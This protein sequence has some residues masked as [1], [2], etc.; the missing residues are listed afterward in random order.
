MPRPSLFL[1]LHGESEAMSRYYQL[2]LKRIKAIYDEIQDVRQ[3][4][5]NL[6]WVGRIPMVPADDAEIMAR[7]TGRI[8]IA[9]LIADDQIGVVRA[10]Q[11]IRLQEVK[12]PNLK[13]GMKISQEMLSL[14]RRIEG[15]IATKGDATIF[16]NYITRSLMNLRDGV[17]QRMEA[18]HNAMLM[19]SFSYSKMGIIL[20]GVTWGMPSDLKVTIGTA[21][22]DT[23]N[24]TPVNDIL[25]VIR[26]AQEKYGIR[27]NR[28]T[29]TTTDFLEMVATTEFR[30]KAALYAQFVL[31]T[32][33]TFPTNDL[34]M[35]KDLGSRMLGGA[36]IELYD[37][38]YWD[39]S[40]YGVQTASNYQT[41]GKIVLT[42]TQADN[43]PTYWDWANAEVTEMV[44]ADMFGGNII[45]MEEGG[46]EDFRGPVGYATVGDVN[47]NPPGPIL[48]GAGRGFTRRHMEAVSACLTNP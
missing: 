10:P 38:Q 35:M 13:H 21:W 43:D 24:A 8:L 39:E 22:T 2:A 17:Y 20:S 46:G 41:A 25:T 1:F 18:I 12:V 23:A 36:V 30:N 9:D 14:L 4:P 28:V 15:Q 3:L 7:Y 34:T 19:D 42:T 45:G 40:L 16:D 5:Q 31:P 33:G 11:P 29:M 44:V 27:L 6:L 47:L 32:S 26:T 48:W 37:A